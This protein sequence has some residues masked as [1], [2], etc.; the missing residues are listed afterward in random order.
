MGNAGIKRQKSDLMLVRVIVTVV[1]VSL[2]QSVTYLMH[3]LC[4]YVCRERYNLMFSVFLFQWRN[5]VIHSLSRGIA[6]H[7]F[8]F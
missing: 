8:R 2:L 7:R 4:I 6:P 3:A 5:I 1:V